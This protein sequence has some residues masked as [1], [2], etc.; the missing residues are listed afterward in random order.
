M[1]NIVGAPY[2]FSFNL[3]GPLNAIQVNAGPLAANQSYNMAASV[4]NVA[5]SGPIVD[6]DNYYARDFFINLLNPTSSV[7]ANDV[8]SETPPDL[9]PFSPY[10]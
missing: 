10:L 4:N 3:A 9:S 7:F 6:G 5:P 8:L 2:L 1:T